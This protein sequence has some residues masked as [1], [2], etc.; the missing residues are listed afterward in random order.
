[1]KAA[2]LP[3]LSGLLIAPEAIAAPLSNAG[4]AAQSSRNDFV[5]LAQGYDFDVFIDQYGREVVLDPQTGRVVEIRPPAVARPRADERRLQREWELGR[6]EL[7]DDRDVE[8]IE[9][10]RP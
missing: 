4:A 7:Y 5:Q 10:L 3:V 2:F 1:M 8:I 6:R 9:R